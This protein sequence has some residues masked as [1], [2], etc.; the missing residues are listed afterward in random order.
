M[1]SA[2]AVNKVVKVLGKRS[3]AE[4]DGSGEAR[5]LLCDFLGTRGGGCSGD[6]FPGEN[7]R[8]ICKQV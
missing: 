6:A 2:G 3:E 8:I 1:S 4:S 5:V 7:N